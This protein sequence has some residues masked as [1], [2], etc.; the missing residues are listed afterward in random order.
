MTIF[1]KIIDRQVPADIVYED[2]LV[3]AFRDIAPQ[4]P[5]H[6]VLIPKR[7]IV[8]VAQAQED[9]GALLGHLL[10]AAARVARSLGVDGSG[11]RLVTNVGQ[12]GGQSVFH[13]HIHLLA[14]RQMGWPPG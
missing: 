5:V 12:H 11:Y 14:G 4:A 2:D 8:S 9:D 13:L 10:L 3:L 1:Q 6:V 7:P